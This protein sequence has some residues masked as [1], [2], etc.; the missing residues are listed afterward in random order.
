LNCRNCGAAMELFA[1]RRYYFCRYC[2]TFD[3]LEPPETDGIRVLEMPA[4]PLVCIRCSGKLAIAQ[5][6]DSHAVQYCTTCRGALMPRPTFADVV[7]ARRTWAT[8]PP[9]APAPLDPSELKRAVKCPSCTSRMSTH[10]YYG[11]GN[12]IIDGCEKCNLV[13][14]D[15]GELKQIAD[16]PGPDRGVRKIQPR[17]TSDA[18]LPAERSALA[19]QDG[20]PNLLD[21]LLDL[22]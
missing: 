9:E 15:F 20:P 7:Y 8:G 16:A 17:A 1:R 12:V 4:T 5:L 18:L 10:P 13:W 3:F 22:F 6:D 2:G 11:P 21:V 19:A 14:L